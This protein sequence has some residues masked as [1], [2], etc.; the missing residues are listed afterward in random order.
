MCCCFDEKPLSH[1][2]KYLVQ[3]PPFT[4]RSMHESI[5]DISGHICYLVDEDGLPCGKEAA[6]TNH[7]M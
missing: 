7:Q 6:V 4:R 5:E 3:C 1:Q 2:L